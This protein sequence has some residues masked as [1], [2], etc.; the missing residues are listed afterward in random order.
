MDNE[1]SLI[2]RNLGR[3][4]YEET[5]RDMREF[6]QKRDARTD[7]EIWLL[8][9]EPVFTQGLAGKP[10]H[11]LSRSSLIPL[12]ASDRG[13]Q[14]TYHG[15]GQLIAYVLIDIKRKGFGVREFV[16]LLEDSVIELVADFD[17]AARARRDAP[18]VYVEGRKIASLGL[19]V[20]R[21]CSF[22]GI[23]LNLAMDLAPFEQIN[24]CGYAGMQMTQLSELLPESRMPSLES[25]L[26]KYATL[27]ARKLGYA[28]N[29]FH[30]VD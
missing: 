11:M 27:L 26:S 24:P 18:G 6:T 28:E 2:I 16:T 5:W 25:L 12:V 8:E 19:R 7:D 29:C 1:A 13:G 15:P 4:R 9:H 3:Q 30:Y 14:I 20:R 21:G 23:A 17:I 22:H 10:E